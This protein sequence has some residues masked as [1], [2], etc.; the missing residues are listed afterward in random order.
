M[1]SCRRLEFLI[2]DK[3]SVKLFHKIWFVVVLVFNVPPT[4][5][6]IWRRG[7]GLKSH[8]TDW[9]SRESNLRPL[10]YKASG[11]STTPQRFLKIWFTGRVICYDIDR[12]NIYRNHN[13][14]GHKKAIST[15]CT[16]LFLL[17]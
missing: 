16:D 12:L 4:A 11:L 2:Q 1:C 10:V 6:V 17:R 7:H 3:P 13:L 8:P 9:R 15:T 14:L 5:K